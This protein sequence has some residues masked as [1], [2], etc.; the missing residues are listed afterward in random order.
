MGMLQ[1]FKKFAMRGNVMDMAVGIIMG[2]AF[3]KIVSSLVNDVVMPPIGMVL[4]NVDFSKLVIPLGEGDK[5]ATLRYGSFLQSV[6]DFLIVALAI[7]LLVKA[8]NR[9][10]TMMHEEMEQQAPKTKDCPR[11]CS[12]IPIKAVRCPNCTSELAA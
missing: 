7:F 6:V 4:G 1:E 10:T 8:I 11:C 3:G 9:A 12:V 2:A 5:A